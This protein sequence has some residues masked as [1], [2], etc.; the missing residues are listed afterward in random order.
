MFRFILGLGAAAALTGSAAAAPPPPAS[1]FGRLPQIQDIAI[2]PDGAKIATVGGTGERR[3]I[4]IAPVDG[5]KAVAV[6]IGRANVRSV[7]WA[8]DDYL[9]VRS[10][11]LDQL[12]NNAAGGKFVFHLDRDFV[13]GPDGKVLGQLLGNSPE[14]GLA[15]SLPILRIVD[16]PPPSAMVLGLDVS[17]STLMG[18][19]DTRLKQDT[20]LLRWSLWRAQIPS[21]DGRVIARGAADTRMWDVDLQG[22]PRVRFDEDA[23]HHASAILVRAKGASTWTTLA[24][25]DDGQ[26]HPLPEYLGYSDPED[27]VYLAEP[28]PGG[29]RAVRHELK[30]GAAAVV[31]PAE[32]ARQLDLRFDPV[33]DRPVA[34]VTAA[35]GQNDVQWLDASL[36]QLSAKLH[37]AFPGKL[38]DI[39]DWSRG[40]TRMLVSVQGQDSPPKWFLFEPAKGQLSPIGAAYPELEA[41]RLGDTSWITYRARD[42]LEI[43]AY[44]TLPPGPAAGA[45]KLPLVVLVHGGPAARDEPGFDWWTEFLASRGYVVLRPQFRGSGGFGEAFRRAGD[46]EWGGKMQT[47]LLDGVQAL[48]AKG[49]I[50]PARVCI[51]G[52]S[53]GGYAA[54]AGATLHPEAYRCAAAVNGVSD[55]GLFLGETIHAYGRDSDA[56]DYWRQTIGDSRAAG[57]AVSSAS[58]A[59]HVAQVRAPILL[60]ASEQD[61]TVPYEQSVAMQRALEGAGKP[62]QLV[63]LEGDDHYLSNSASRVRMLE[64][65]GAFLAR[66]LPVSP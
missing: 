57:D 50:D 31:G 9:I 33:T 22:E 17:A 21:G 66:N 58:P 62:V 38:V 26:T 4:T 56:I 30:G 41:V 53:Y 29:V 24:S 59:L 27:A 65:L 6:D 13:I 11:I 1:A 39:S 32:P 45:G 52:A 2:S 23:A 16:G 37:R 3:L 15:F 48:A 60:V 49:L 40:R 36:E 55:L 25:T 5:A 28:G 19:T 8:G 14:S 12:K 47:D 64:A 63:S 18:P 35:G 34:I 43:P 46:K 54:L 61:T 20:G 51:V 7:R 42:G 10:S 44:L